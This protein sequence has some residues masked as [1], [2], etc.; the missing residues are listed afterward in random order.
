M[1]YLAELTAYNLST[2]AVETLRFSTGLGYLDA[3][4]GNY[5]APRIEQPA[6]MRREI[7]ADGQIGGAASASFGELTLVNNDGELDYLVG[8]AVDGRTLIIK[9]GEETAAYASFTTILKAIMQQAAHE[10]ERVSIRLRDR[11]AEFSKP[12]QTLK[13]AGTNALPAGI[14]GAADLKDAPKP[15]FYGR[16][17]NI[18]PVLVN[19]S[20]LIYQVTT[21]ALAEVVNVFDNGA[22]LGRGADYT[23]QAHM[24]ANAPSAGY[25]RVWKAGGM[26]RLGSIPA[27]LIT[28]TC[29]EYSTV[30]DITGAA[31]AK[32]LATGPGGV[33][34]DDIVADDYTT[35]NGQNAGSVG[36]WVTDQMTIAEA[37]DR[38]SASL[39]AWWGFDRIGRFRIAR[40]DAPAGEPVAT[41][42]EI[43]IL[44]LSTEAATINGQAVPAWKITL[45]HDINYTMQSGGSVAGGVA[46][47]R[48]AWLEK[49]S[50]QATDEDAAVKTPHPLAQEITYDT[51]LAGQGYAQPEAARRLSLL[52]TQRTIYNVIAQVDAALLDAIDI[53]EVVDV[54]YPRF[55]LNAGKLLRVIG[56][57]PNWK[58]NELTLRLWG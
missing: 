43:E 16:V 36:L 14:E 18:T 56:Y 38:V 54:Q 39:G 21:G 4:T 49:A 13:Y 8:Y 2:E 20:R 57:E 3:A 34:L 58:N 37:M 17:N 52:K 19:S 11:I 30:E 51:L 53:G 46:A 5:Y 23:S 32:R 28:A 7:F 6:L 45:N 33:S 47:D 55:G 27:G 10:W 31:V 42:T 35:L 9:A 50:R 24:E 22:Y 26:F 44:S 25:Y 40:F 1:I 12:I 15:L 41:L 29:W 48:R